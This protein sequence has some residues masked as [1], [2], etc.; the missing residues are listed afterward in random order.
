MK[1]NLLKSVLTGLVLLSATPVFAA[2]YKI[3]PDH[4]SVGFKIKHLAI[5]SVSGR[6]TEFTGEFAYDPKN[7]TASKAAATIA[8][9]SISTEA[10]KRDDHLKSP[11]FFDE[12]KFPE[13]SFKSTKV[14]AG[15]GDAF[16]VTGDLTIH[17]VTKSVVLDVTAGGEAKDPWGKE[18]AAFSATTKINR[19]DFGLTWNKVLETGGLVVGDEVT[20]TLEIEGIK[21]QEKA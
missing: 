4:S 16:Q 18:R 20:I 11:D 7:V 9:K 14:Q 15:A 8:I 19:K 6:F 21:E 1:I 17:G 10:K 3:D 5:S 12:T 2:N 13:I